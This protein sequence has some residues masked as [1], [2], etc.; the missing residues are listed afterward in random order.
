MPFRAVAF[1]FLFYVNT[2]AHVVL[3]LPALVMPGRR[4]LWRAVHSWITVN[5]WLLRACCGISHEIRFRGRVP[6]GP[7]LVA[8]K[9]QSTWDIF[10]LLS[11]FGDPVFILKREVMWLPFFNLYCLKGGMIPVERGAR[12][13][14]LNKMLAYA[15]ARIRAQRQ[16]LIFPE[17]TRKAP[18]AEP[19]YKYGVVQ[20]YAE[21]GVPCLPIALNSGLY[22]PRRTLRFRQG[23]IR[24][25]VLPPIPPGLSEQVFLE[26]LQASIET[27]TNRLLAEGERE[28]AGLGGVCKPSS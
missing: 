15:R 1:T 8:A 7:L 13:L 27:A 3:A 12:S 4:A 16:I 9:H 26:R 21:L 18:G 24:A 19:D 23:T 5:H 2:I 14:A 22:W 11:L 10:P 28:L 25:E 20:L 6:P 17:G